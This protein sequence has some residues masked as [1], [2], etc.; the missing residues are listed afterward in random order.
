M[1]SSLSGVRRVRGLPAFTCVVG[2]TSPVSR[3]LLKSSKHTR[4]SVWMTST[5][6]T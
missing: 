5:R 3:T 4:I 6:I 2:I 1:A